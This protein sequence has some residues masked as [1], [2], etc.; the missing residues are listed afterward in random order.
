MG[1][2]QVDSQNII[3]DDEYSLRDLTGRKLT[4][5]QLDNKVIY[6]TCFSHEQPDSI[7]F[8]DNMVDATFVNCNLDNCFIPSGNTVI[9]GSQRR[10]K[11]QNDL[12]DWE[13]D[14]ANKPVKLVNE[15][16][17]QQAGYS[18]DPKDIPTKKQTNIEETKKVINGS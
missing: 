17:W 3:Y 2:V 6:A 9:G 8:S 13:I 18:I 10:F 11:V 15:E 14:E 4:E 1:Q 5:Y 7:V 16:M 12:R